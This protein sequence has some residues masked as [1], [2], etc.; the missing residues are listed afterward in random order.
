[1][2]QF[3]FQH[4]PPLGQR[5][6]NGAH[7]DQPRTCDRCC[8]EGIGFQIVW[9]CK[10]QNSESREE[11]RTNKPFSTEGCSGSNKYRGAGLNLVK[12][13]C[14]HVHYA[15]YMTS[16]VLCDY[17][18]YKYMR[19]RIGQYDSLERHPVLRSMASDRCFMKATP[20]SEYLACRSDPLGLIHGRGNVQLLRLKR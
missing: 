14:R 16:K 15:H 2:L 20:S 5:N 12:L 1:M 19:R 4:L 7:R 17:P 18:C 9:D 3:S 13:M 11:I 10:L 8:L 6:K